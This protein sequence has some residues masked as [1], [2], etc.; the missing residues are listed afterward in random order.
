MFFVGL[1]GEDSTTKK[2]FYQYICNKLYEGGGG[3]YNYPNCSPS[4]HFQ[5]LHGTAAGS[6]EGLNDSKEYPPLIVEKHHSSR[7]QSM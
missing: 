7:K 2:N 3:G 1:H 4:E 6:I 5:W